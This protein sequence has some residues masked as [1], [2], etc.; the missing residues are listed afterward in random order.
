MTC[1]LFHLVNVG[2]YHDCFVSVRLGRRL[3]AIASSKIVSSLPQQCRVAS[4][5]E[6][7]KSHKPHAGASKRKAKVGQALKPRYAKIRQDI[8]G[9]AMAWPEKSQGT[10][11][12]AR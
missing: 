1:L 5:G 6:Q 11:F 4:K 10:G 9:V 12:F 7:A 3:L 2:T 8:H